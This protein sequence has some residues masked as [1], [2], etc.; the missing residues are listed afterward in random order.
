MRQDAS[1]NRAAILSAARE[2]LGGFDELRLSAVAKRAGVGQATLYR[3]FPTQDALLAAVYEAEIGELVLAADRLVAEQ[4]PVE[5]LR[6][7][8]ARLADYVR[9]KR[10]VLEAVAMSTWEDLSASTMGK[11]GDALGTLLDAGVASHEFREGIDPRDV[12][13]LSWF[14]A[15]V[16]PEEWDERVPRLLD[17][18]VAG[19]R[20]EP[21]A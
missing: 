15:H 13:L 12:I 4:P 1:R 11:L 16:T 14:M 10:G 18:L 17:V 3:H 7:W 2:I 19:L 8:F 20:T 6:A 5:A 21:H 9:V